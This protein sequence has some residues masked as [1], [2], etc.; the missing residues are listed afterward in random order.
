VFD[1]KLVCLSLISLA[2]SI[3]LHKVKIDGPE[4]EIDVPKP[5]ESKEIFLTH[6]NMVLVYFYKVQL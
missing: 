6:R 1:K 3:P 2:E 4:P 5:F